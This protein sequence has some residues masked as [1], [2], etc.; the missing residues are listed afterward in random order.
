VQVVACEQIGDSR[1][2]PLTS[3]S[4]TQNSQYIGLRFSLQ[5][6]V[7]IAYFSQA[8]PNIGVTIPSKKGCFFQG[9]VAGTR[10]RKLLPANEKR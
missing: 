5:A 4:H 9:V 6:R 10:F 1:S 8:L 2:P 7:S 3:C